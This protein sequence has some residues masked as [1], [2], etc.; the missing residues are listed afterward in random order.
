M[1]KEERQRESELEKKKN[2]REGRCF[3]FT[4]IT[5]THVHFFKN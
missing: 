4:G 2:E 3:L 5:S 1:E